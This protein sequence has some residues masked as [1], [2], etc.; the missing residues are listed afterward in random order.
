MKLPTQ[1]KI[2]RED[3]KGA[4]E[5]IDAVITPI[6]SFMESV[7]NALNRNITFNENIAAFEKEI[8]YRTPT[9]YPVMDNVTFVNELRTRARGVMLMQVVDRATYEPPVGPV[10]V[11]WIED[12]KGIVIK[13]I[14][15]L[16]ADKTYQ[17]RLL[18]I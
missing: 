17:V 13:P 16:V 10:Y 14:Q 12:N 6:N 2:I 15:G 7:Y 3:V 18:V 4:P 9:T 8:I 5:W 11:P 1:K